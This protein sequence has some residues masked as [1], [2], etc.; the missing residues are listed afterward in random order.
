[1]ITIYNHY[2]ANNV[3]SN[4]KKIL[5]NKRVKNLNDKGYPIHFEW[6]K[7]NSLSPRIS[8]MNYD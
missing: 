5:N 6:C 2:E 8:F 3:Y 7:H 4:N 1:M